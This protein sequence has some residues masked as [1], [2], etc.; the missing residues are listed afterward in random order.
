LCNLI[1]VGRNRK[2]VLT[3]PG[4]PAPPEQPELPLYYVASA[5]DTPPLPVLRADR[6]WELA[7]WGLVPHWTRTVA[8]AKKIRAGAVN[9]RSE[10]MWERPAFELAARNGRC[11][12]L[13]DGFFEFHHH[14]GVAFPFY[15]FLDGHPDFFMAGLRD[16]WTNPD[17]GE[18]EV[19]CTVVTTAANSFMREIHNKLPDPEERRMPVIVPADQAEAWLSLSTPIEKLKR[20]VSTREIPEMCA[21]NVSRTLNNAKKRVNDPSA[22]EPVDYPELD[23]ILAFLATNR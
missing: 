13:V 2:R 14:L 6:E 15:V 3:I 17:T 12:I 5:F 19:T 16:M 9:A 7:K 1:S 22:Q 10:S 18:T 4:I 8:Q 23:R 11:L 21:H 20:I